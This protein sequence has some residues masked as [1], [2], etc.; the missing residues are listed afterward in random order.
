ME[1]R[2][3]PHANSDRLSDRSDKVA[4]A[5]PA[6]HSAQLNI[7]RRCLASE[8]CAG[9]VYVPIRTA[10]TMPNAWLTQ[11]SLGAHVA[12]NPTRHFWV[13]GTARYLPD[14]ADKTRQWGYCVN[15]G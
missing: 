15:T 6:E 12:L 8:I 13:G 4:Q 14:F 7:D 11:V 9:G 1:F 10:Y 3:P 2:T 5:K